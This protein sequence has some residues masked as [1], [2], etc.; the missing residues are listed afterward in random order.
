MNAEKLKYFLYEEA[1]SLRLIYNT[2]FWFPVI[3]NDTEI[4]K[5]PEYKNLWNSTIKKNPIKDFLSYGI[6]VIHQRNIQNDCVFD[7]GQGVWFKHPWKF[8]N[9]IAKLIGTYVALNK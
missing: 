6:N 1:A 8:P 4:L 2:Q 3:R 5:I 9:A 7:F